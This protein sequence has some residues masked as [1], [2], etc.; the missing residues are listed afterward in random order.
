M[1]QVKCYLYCNQFLLFQVYNDK[2]NNMLAI[3]FQSNYL[4]FE[5]LYA[6]A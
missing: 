1:S 6:Y 5:T 2:N 3:M 4:L